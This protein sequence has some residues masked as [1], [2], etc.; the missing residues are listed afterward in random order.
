MKLIVC[1]PQ[2]SAR[3]IAERRRTGGDRFDEVWEGVYVMSPLAND[4]HQEIATGLSGVF[5]VVL[6]WCG[7]A[8]VRTGVNVSDRRKKWKHNF[9][10]PDVAVF[11]QDCKA[12][13]CGSFW[14][15]G[16]D[17]A[18]EVVSRKDRSRK[19][20]GFYAKVGTRE[21]LIVDRYP[22]ALDLYALK[23]NSLELVGRSTLDDPQLLQSSVLPPSF[24]LVAG[25]ERPAIQVTQPGR[26]EPWLL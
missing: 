5:L 6:A 26:D 23:G 11:L 14:F 21:S 12:Q 8:R 7:L 3:L 18:V 19:K 20:F 24:R 25:T 2:D 4:E 10:C 17:F 15:G 1:D 16:P 13:L 9:R 22:W